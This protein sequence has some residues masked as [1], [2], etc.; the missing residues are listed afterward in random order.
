VQHF[1]LY[2]YGKKFKLITDHKPLT[3]LYK[4]KD[5]IS[6]LARWRI[7]LA[8]YDY[9]I[10]YKLDKIKAKVTLSRNP[11][12]N[13][14]PIHTSY[15]EIEKCPDKARWRNVNP[16]SLPASQRKG[17]MREESEP[18]ITGMRTCHAE[19]SDGESISFT[20]LE[21]SSF[22]EHIVHAEI[23]NN[24]PNQ[25]NNRFLQNMKTPDMK[26]NI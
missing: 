12:T 2:L 8:E 4:L 10:I 22:I 21:E 7:K 20:E 25:S 17:T 15:D 5:A 6:Q 13:I 1:R 14:Y 3:W 11:T 9:E 24:P 23:H 26:S 18:I 16:K 19:T